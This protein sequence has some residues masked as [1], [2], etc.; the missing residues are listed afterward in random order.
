M[1]AFAFVDVGVWRF[2]P[3]SSIRALIVDIVRKLTKMSMLKFEIEWF[4]EKMKFNIS[5]SIMKDVWV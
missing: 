1:C 2:F 4:D 5:L 3:T